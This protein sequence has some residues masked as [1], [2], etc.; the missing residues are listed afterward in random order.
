MYV[1][2]RT[3]IKQEWKYVEAPW[4]FIA[5]QFKEYMSVYNMPM[6]Y[7]M[8]MQIAF[9]AR[10]LLKKLDMQSAPDNLRY[11]KTLYVKKAGV[12]SRQWNS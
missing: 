3:L 1:Y 7:K 4:V 2:T 6:R 10:E 9:E 11:K 5:T 8:N 12:P